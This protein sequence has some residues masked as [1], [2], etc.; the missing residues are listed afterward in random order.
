MD[1]F[2]NP[3][4]RDP[5][6]KKKPDSRMVW[7]RH[8]FID[9]GV[10]L[11]LSLHTEGKYHRH[12]MDGPNN[13]VE[14]SPP[15]PAPCICA[16]PVRRASELLHARDH[17]RRRSFKNEER[18]GHS[19]GHSRVLLR[20]EIGRRASAMRRDRWDMRNYGVGTF[21]FEGMR[22]L[23]LTISP[24]ARSARNSNLRRTNR[25]TN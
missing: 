2:T 1:Q 17:N 6:W 18:N 20:H 5:V 7:V 4:G 21:S 13:S 8:S 24:F 15:I 14:E 9:S 10:L 19:Q 12:I 22:K 11:S 25:P 23:R 3:I 16:K